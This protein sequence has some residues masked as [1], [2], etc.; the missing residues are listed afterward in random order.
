MEHHRC[1]RRLAWFGALIA[2]TACEASAPGV[3]T[4]AIREI[5]PTPSEVLVPLP[6]GTLI[7]ERDGRLLQLDPRNAN[8]EPRVV[9]S[10]SELGRVH[11]A[12]RT[13]EA[14]LVL[15]EGGTFVLRES[16]WVPSPL[17]EALDGPIRD[18]EALP[19]PTGRG[20]GDLWIV[21]DRSL[22]RVVGE[23][24]ERLALEDD[25]RGARLAGVQR[26]EGPALWARLEDRV[27]EIWRDRSGVLRSARLVLP[28]VPT[29][30]AGDASGTGWLVL[31][32]RLHSLGAD[33][34]LIDHGVDV[35]RLLGAGSA[36]ALWALGEGEQ[37]VHADGRLHRAES[38]DVAPDD[39][40]ALGIDGSLYT[41][42]PTVRRFAPRRDVV[43]DG[44]ADGLL[45]VTP[46][47]FVL[48]LEGSPTV[49]ARL[50]GV[51]IEVA[52]EPLSVAIR[53][54]EL[55]DGE[56][57]LVIEVRYDDGTL[58]FVARRTFHVVSNASWTEHVRPLY[59]AECASCHGPEGPANTRLDTREDW[60]TR[61][62]LIL[63]NLEEGR[64]PLGRPPLTQSQIA[65][66]QAWV[67][68]G[69]AE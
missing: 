55:A 30:V 32:G 50:D 56:H 6:D 65:Y 12:V 11:A 5:F 40:L 43:I 62:T 39:V 54:A 31:D 59:Q 48:R 22:Y 19:T 10:S 34:R 38:V 24:A 57:Q 58:P 13:G 27:L 60:M 7:V 17:A 26:P 64:M 47:T 33:R 2:L 15:A 52:R 23:R 69:F 51:P 46:Q 67:L 63:M 1:A 44:P 41:A 29:D 36:S 25:L 9:G 49:E 42:S 14:V 21:T 37:W 8:D 66:V 4:P 53:P 35:E 45:L 16:A 61:A 20:E 28:S 68:G 3:V 18:A